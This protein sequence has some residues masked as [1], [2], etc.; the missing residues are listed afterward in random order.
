MVSVRVAA[1]RT[2]HVGNPAKTLDGPRSDIALLD[3]VRRG[4]LRA[5]VVLYERHA[6]GARRLARAMLRNQASWRTF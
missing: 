1:G 3:E 5:Y 4:D 2:S 6:D